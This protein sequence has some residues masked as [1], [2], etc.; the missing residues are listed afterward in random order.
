MEDINKKITG[1]LISLLGLGKLPEEDRKKVSES[2]QEDIFNSI[3][4]QIGERLSQEQCQELLNFLEAADAQGAL[5][6]LRD[7]IPDV[8]LFAISAVSDAIDKYRA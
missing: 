6:Y 1:D 7:C 5:A 4:L 3:A 8:D 2:A